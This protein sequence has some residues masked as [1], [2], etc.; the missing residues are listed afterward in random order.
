MPRL[1][2]QGALADPF[3][4]PGVAG[5]VSAADVWID[6][7]FPYMAGCHVHDEVTRHGKARY[8]LGGDMG[9]GGLLRLFGAV[10]LDSYF[11]A[12]RPFEK[13]LTRSEEHTSELQS[14]MRISYAVLCFKKTTK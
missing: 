11:T 3:I 1:P 4:P 8:L 14:L 2:F 6:F 13:S 12:L 10:D 7:T 9:L 5:A